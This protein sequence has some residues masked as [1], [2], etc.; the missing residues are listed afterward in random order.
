M[1]VTDHNLEDMLGMIESERCIHSGTIKDISYTFY[2]YTLSQ[3]IKLDYFNILFGGGGIGNFALE[4][5]CV[6]GNRC[7][8]SLPIILEIFE[9]KKGIVARVTDS[10]EGFDFKEV[11]KRFENGEKYY[12]GCGFGFKAYNEKEFLVSFENDG[13]MVNIL[14]FFYHNK[15]KVF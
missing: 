10:G 6:R 7:D 14:Y 4:N 8:E 3:Q 15:F 11:Q 13:K 2:V 5:A 1:T 12:S 9:G